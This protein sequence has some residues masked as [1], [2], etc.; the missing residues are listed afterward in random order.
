MDKE[1]HMT[2]KFEKE[3]HAKRMTRRQFMQISAL[4]A[5]V[6]LMPIYGCAVDPV[7]GKKS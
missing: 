2:K 5:A 3:A 4:T 7:T 1:R 6:G